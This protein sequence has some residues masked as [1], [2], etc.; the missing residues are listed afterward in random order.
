MSHS[1]VQ[2]PLSEVFAINTL[3]G[4]GRFSNFDPFGDASAE[5]SVWETLHERWHDAATSPCKWTQWKNS[6]L[7]DV[8][9]LWYNIRTKAYAITDWMLD[10]WTSTRSLTSPPYVGEC[11]YSFG[12][13]SGSSQI[14]RLARRYKVKALYSP[15]SVE[16]TLSL[17]RRLMFAGL[18]STSVISKN[19]QQGILSP[20]CTHHTGDASNLTRAL[21]SA[22]SGV[23]NSY[24]YCPRW[25]VFFNVAP[26]VWITEVWYVQI[27]CSGVISEPWFIAVCLAR[28]QDD[29]KWL[30]WPRCMVTIWSGDFPLV[31]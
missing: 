23:K 24:H 20:I 4:V 5:K 22:A 29:D 16:E 14:T 8:R 9:L 25:F 7:S 12:W 26:T 31:I 11:E 18:S 28:L 19:L 21:S 2:R 15:I 30:Y 1:H 10:G 3:W 27:G 6:W 17:S 13:P